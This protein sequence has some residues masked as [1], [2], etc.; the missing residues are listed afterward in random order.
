LPH[1]Q[2]LFDKH[3]DS[4]VHFFAVERSGLSPVEI[5]SFAGEHGWTLPFVA[6]SESKLSSYDMATMPNIYVINGHGRVVYQGGGEYEKFLDAALK[7]VKY[8]ELGK[9]SVVADCEKAAQSFGKRDYTKARQMAEAL[10]EGE[11]AE[12]V[13]ADARYI[14]ERCDYFAKTWREQADSAKEAKLYTR[15]T[16]ALDRIASHFKGSDLGTAAAEE[17]KALKSDKDIKASM[18]ARKDL[19]KQLLANKKL[20]TKADKVAALA[21]FHERNAGTAAADEAK[22]IAEALQ[23]SQWFK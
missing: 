8:P 20:K 9:L 14:I 21:K 22:A 3:K 5:Q 10:L 1:F 23:S 11:P 7:D 17:S 13:A 15:A 6:L 2:K 4:G 19:E 12:D 16:D 18:K